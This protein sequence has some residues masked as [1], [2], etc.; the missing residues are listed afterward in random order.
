MKPR[1][2][3]IGILL[4]VLL[5]S[6]CGQ[7]DQPP[8]KNWWEE[9]NLPQP[10]TAES[11]DLSQERESPSLVEGQPVVAV[12]EAV[13]D[14]SVDVR[15]EI[16]A[17]I[18]QAYTRY[19]GG[20]V[21]LPAGRYRIDS[22]LRIKGNVTLMGEW[23]S[24][25]EGVDGSRTV[26]EIYDREG[27][28]SALGKGTGT[29]ELDEN[30]GLRNLTIYYPNQGKNGI[31]AYPATITNRAYMMSSCENL[32]IVNAYSGIEINGHNQSHYRNIEMTA[33]YNGFYFNGIREVPVL[34]NLRISPYYWSV[35]DGKYEEE[36]LRSQLQRRVTGFTLGF[37]DWIYAYGLE[38]DG[39]Q[40]GIRFVSGD[41][42]GTV[43]STNGQFD[44]LNIERCE[45]ALRFEAANGIGNT[46]ARSHFS[47][48]G[49]ESAVVVCGAE[50]G[51][52]ALFFDDCG[53][54]GEGEIV[55]HTEA[56][57]GLGNLFF[58]NCQFEEWKEG[59]YALDV[60]N[61][62]LTL[63]SCRFDQNGGLYLSGERF[64]YAFLTD[65][66][67]LD[68]RTD[69]FAQNKYS[70]EQGYEI[71]EL[72]IDLPAGREFPDPAEEKLYYADDFG[73]VS[74]PE[75]QMFEGDLSALKDSALSIQQ[76]LNAAAES[77]G[78]IVM[79]GKGYYRLDQYL[80]IPAGVELRGVSENVKHFGVAS[81]GTVLVTCDYGKDDPDRTPLIT[82][83]EGAGVYGL[84][85][86]YQGQV[87]PAAGQT[88]DTYQNAV[89]YPVT[90]SLPKDRSYLGCVTVVNGYESI[91]V[92]GKDAYLFKLRGL[93]L[94]TFLTLDGADRTRIDYLLG[95]GG[96]W[97]D[98]Y[99][100]GDADIPSNIPPSTWWQQF[101]NY[102]YATGV[103]IN[104]SD[105][106]TLY[107]SFVFGFGTG[108]K[109]TG[110][111]SRLQ[112]YG[113][114]V[115][116]SADGVVIEGAGTD[117]VFLGSELVSSDHSIWVKSGYEGEVSFFLT[118]CWLSPD[119][120]QECLIED[121]TVTLQGYKST[122][123]GITVTGGR[124]MISDVLLTSD[125][126]ILNGETQ[127]LV[128][129]CIGPEVESLTAVSV[130]GSG[131]DRTVR[132][133]N[134]AGDRATLV[135]IRTKS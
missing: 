8:Q 60:S 77:G 68:V 117:N 114:G 86:Y 62:F 36:M 52:S 48:E 56:T 99:G 112:A 24:L 82:L 5:L 66:E 121:G 26:L 51:D 84:T 37:I 13:N 69:A 41:H 58:T 103:E 119:H 105:D 12:V 104:N 39:C 118:N 33:L 134:Q 115:D 29:F 73:A 22:A 16:Q 64:D 108:L 63:T 106:V 75:Y 53:F 129:L 89:P 110:E 32:T 131:S 20:V 2:V 78:G 80:V 19:S 55:S 100:V 85:V 44:G 120:R 102:R 43:G 126:R 94:K 107:E 76:A 79:L 93:G 31:K 23:S 109:L 133:D 91:K 124:V 90:F 113:F 28:S 15:D 96:D 21:F 14:G 6:A 111:V 98:C 59:G 38:V 125:A 1:H 92:S 97:Q 34:E 4:L 83:G 87:P 130:L 3:L 88:A 40:T 27:V 135:H 49:E 10:I 47:A 95:T 57:D 122:V 127:P 67:G 7:G 81:R 65:N 72:E 11:T 35:Y 132:L 42:G 50:F 9:Q 46:F 25:D 128:H 123:G 70:V 45:T 54:S 101:P 116:A 30:A 74:Y 71:P 17:A 18:D 61:G